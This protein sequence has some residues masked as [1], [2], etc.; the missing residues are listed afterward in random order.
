MV[1]G[2]VM[3]LESD[4]GRM[5]SGVG[6]GGKEKVVS[7]SSP[8]LGFPAVCVSSWCLSGSEE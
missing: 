1:D 4:G 5:S 8:L 2:R 6:E 7:V 3:G